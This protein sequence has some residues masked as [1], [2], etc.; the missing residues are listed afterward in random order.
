MCSRCG[1]ALRV[2]VYSRFDSAI[3]EA[4]SQISFSL[5]CG[6]LAYCFC[7]RCV[8]MF[9]LLCDCVLFYSRCGCVA[10]FYSRYGCVAYWF[11]LRWGC[12]AYRRLRFYLQALFV[13]IDTA[14]L[15]QLLA[16]RLRCVLFIARV[17]VASRIGFWSIIVKCLNSAAMQHFHLALR[18]LFTCVAVALRTLFNCLVVALRIVFTCVAYH[19]LSIFLFL[20]RSCS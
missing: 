19:I 11:Y 16:L 14:L 18:I 12:V 17:A 15:M 9:F 20:W 4:A 5:H 2:G 10:Y 6:F 7:L 3:I 8:L 1:R 13:C